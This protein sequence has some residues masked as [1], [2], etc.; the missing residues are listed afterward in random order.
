MRLRHLRGPA[1]ILV[2]S[3]A[4]LAALEGGVRLVE[5]VRTGSFP[6]TRDVALHRELRQVVRLYQRHPFLNTGPTAEVSISAFGKHVTL[7]SLGYRSP[8]RPRARPPG[9]AR[10]LCAGGSTTFDLLAPNDGATWPQRLEAMLTDRGREVEVWNAAFPGWT[11]LENTI[12]LFLRDL[13]LAPDV[14]V[15]FQGINDLQPAAHQPF[16]PQY[17]RGHA[18]LTR[19]ALG[20]EGTPLAW[21]RRSV[22]VERLR[23]LIYGPS[24]PW[25]RA[26]PRPPDLERRSRL[27]AEAVAVF[28]RNVSAFAE[29]AR[30]RGASVLLV[31]QSV[32]VR[33]ATPEADLSLLA[34]WIPGLEPAAAPQALDRLNRV[35]REVAR[36]GAADLADAARDVPWQDRDFGD[37]MHFS[38]RGSTRLAEYLAP[39]VDGLL[40][41]TDRGR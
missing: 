40:S 11:S 18:E 9:V 14:V 13:D 6:V 5:R 17:V 37:A 22:L 21:R 31:S 27:P 33:E 23:D 25:Q 24:D 1:L 16:D 32:R 7:N 19:R 12:A 3:A 41:A 28:R 4:L 36:E 8:E 30:A 10:V 26:I 34:E 38:E 2:L 39:R 35:L 15:L 20:L 29:L